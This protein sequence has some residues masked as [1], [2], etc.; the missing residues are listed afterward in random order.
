M[1]WVRI[2]TL[3][4]AGKVA[5]SIFIAICVFLGFGPD[6]WVEFILGPAIAPWIGRTLL[7]VLAILTFIFIRFGERLKTQRSDNSGPS[8]DLG[9]EVSQ[10]AS[11]PDD[12]KIT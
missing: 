10:I 6:K 2:F 11:R 5:G 1:N 9:F 7:F 8:F 12:Q 3:A 4:F